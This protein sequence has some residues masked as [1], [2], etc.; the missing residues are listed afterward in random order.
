MNIKTRLLE[1]FVNFVD[2][3]KKQ[4]KNFKKVIILFVVL[5]CLSLFFALFIYLSK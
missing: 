2:L 4:N 1:E 3:T 5:L